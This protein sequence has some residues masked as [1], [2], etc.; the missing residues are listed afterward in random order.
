V[1]IPAAA[2]VLLV[3][4]LLSWLLQLLQLLL[5]LLRLLWSGIDWRAVEPTFFDYRSLCMFFIS[6]AFGNHLRSSF[7]NPNRMK[8]LR[9]TGSSLVD[10]TVRLVVN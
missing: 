8:L 6:G 1:V 7:L 2:A 9:D 10:T 5:L 4:V 3:R